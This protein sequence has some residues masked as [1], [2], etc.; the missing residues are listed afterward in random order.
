MEYG[1]GSAPIH[2]PGSTPVLARRLGEP[3]NLETWQPQNWLTPGWNGP[4]LV[5]P[6]THTARKLQGMFCKDFA[7]E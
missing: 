1:A 6:K 3:K 5:T 2:R 4:H 7:L